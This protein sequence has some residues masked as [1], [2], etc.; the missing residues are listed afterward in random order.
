MYAT[1]LEIYA[2]EKLHRL[3]VNI[4]LGIYTLAC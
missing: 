1:K 4:F 2:A 3:E